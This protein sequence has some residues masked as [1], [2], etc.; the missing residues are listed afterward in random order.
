M[1]SSDPDHRAVAAFCRRLRAATGALGMSLWTATPRAC[2]VGGEAP[3]SADPLRIVP[4]R[5]GD[6]RVGEIRWQPAPGGSVPSDTAEWL[7]DAAADL[8]APLLARLTTHDAGEGGGEPFGLVGA[9]TAM[10]ALRQAIPRAA[11]SP[12]PVLIEGESGVGKELVARAVHGASRRAGRFV[13]LNC[14]ALADE[15][16]DAE[17]F[18]H[19]RGAFTGAATERCGLFEAAQNGTLFL[20]EVAELSARGQAKLLR[21]LQEG[22]LRRVG[23]NTSRRVDVRLVAATNRPLGGE[24]AA[25]RFRADLRFRLDVVRLRVPPLRERREDIPALAEHFWRVAAAQVGSR[26]VLA[27]SLLMALT[28]GDWPGNARELQN[29]LAGLAV[30]APVRGLVGCAE[31]GVAWRPHESNRP[32]TLAAARRAF[33]AA[34]V[35]AALARCGERPGVAARELGVSRQGLAKL[36]DRLGLRPPPPRVTLRRAM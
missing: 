4:V 14:A 7:V 19:A 24:V 11:A 12:F 15:L 10:R 17:L 1:V 31:L 34:F 23:E 30:R 18:G 8:L 27:P 9:S 22:E 16:L 21:V 20:D 13:G 35:R 29:L 33:D 25:G 28:A 6:D 32:I 5:Y 2:I 36:M 26:A 3:A